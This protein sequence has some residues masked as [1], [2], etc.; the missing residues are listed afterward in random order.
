M[1]VDPPN[2]N[3]RDPPAKLL[4]RT[5]RVGAEVMNTIRVPGD[6]FMDKTG[7][8]FDRELSS[9]SH[10]CIVFEGND[11][12]YMIDGPRT[13]K[14]MAAAIRTATGAGHFIYFANW[15]CDL[16]MPLDG[17]SLWTLI[18]AAADRPFNRANEVMVRAMLWRRVGDFQNFREVDR[19]NSLHNG[20]AILDQTGNPFIPV[21]IFGIIPVRF[22]A[23]HQKILCVFGEKGLICFCGGVDFNRDRTEFHGG[24]TPLHDVHC[25]IIGPAALDVLFVF[26]QRWNTHS[27]GQRL[28]RP[29]SSGGKGP[30]LGV[31]AAPPAAGPHIVQIG[32]TYGKGNYSFAPDGE[33][34]A[35]EIIKSGILNAERFV[36]T[37]DQY[38]IGS[39]ELEHTLVR[40]LEENGI[41]FVALITDWR[42]CDLPLAQKH[43]RDLI[44][45]LRAAGG[46]RVRIFSRR[47]PGSQS[48]FN[49]GKIRHSYVHAKIWIADDEFA[50][51]GTVNSNRRGWSH[52]S[53]FTAG[54]YDTS[55]EKILTY[56]MAHRLR[57]DLWQEHLGM[58][59]AD[60]AAE[61]ADGFAS[62]AHWVPGNLPPN[63]EIKEY[64]EDEPDT[65]FPA[66]ISSI[67]ILG[68]LN[69]DGAYFTLVDP[70]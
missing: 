57:I 30:L 67:P 35:R 14:E 60:G 29:R 45:R 12:E 40:A 54:I 24:G 33:T 17:A 59:G 1:A 7:L 25:R 47:P 46:D 3:D 4:V 44:K 48:D 49:S 37:E 53:E 69:T 2:K 55:V 6:P 38:F 58:P 62:T 20:A 63:A 16:D 56:R 70:A 36:Y 8:W 39:P 31:S 41:V 64:N 18:S 11:V 10:K 27:D 23:Q 34:T 68:I 50:S 66:L 42:V 28:N 21:P 9:G 15:W 32:R 26:T 43:R 22:G 51:I 5:A 19:I 61:L 52:D 13:L 65:N